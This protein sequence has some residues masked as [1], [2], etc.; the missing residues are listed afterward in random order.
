MK[1]SNGIE[2]AKVKYFKPDEF[3]SPDSNE[4]IIKDS[5]VYQLDNLRMHYGKPIKIT[6]GYRTVEHNVKVGGVAGS[7]HRAGLAVD[8]E[9]LTSEDRFRLINLAMQCRFP[10][11][12]IGKTFVHLDIDTGKPLNIIWLYEN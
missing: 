9:V 1:D 12:G 6:S 11:I 8:I 2:W 3:K 4:L 7:S 5:L 10:R